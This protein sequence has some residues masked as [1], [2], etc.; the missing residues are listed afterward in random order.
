MNARRGTLWMLLAGLWAGT[1][2]PAWAVTLRWKPAPGATASYT[3]SLVSDTRSVGVGNRLTLSAARGRLEGTLTMVRPPKPDQ[4]ALDCRM[5]G[6]R[7]VV[8][9]QG[10][11]EP[12][13]VPTSVERVVMTPLGETVDWKLTRGD[14]A[15]LEPPMRLML[16]PGDLCVFEGY[17]AFPERDL[18]PGDTW[19]GYYDEKPSGPGE[20]PQRI[21]YQSTLMS[22]GHFRGRPCA[23]IA[24]TYQ[25]APV[26]KQAPQPASE[27][28]ATL[29]AGDV[30]WCFDV[31]RSMILYYT[32]TMSTTALLTAQEGNQ[33]FFASLNSQLRIVAHMTRYGGAP[34]AGPGSKSRRTN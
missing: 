1:S 24:T 5:T 21:S 32:E 13:R 3:L 33:P 30:F 11:P 18:K 12:R 16:E 27:P 28:P 22:L 29:M 34:L 26:P 15:E 19:S 23:R 31:E 2:L 20:E 7:L 8:W 6:G 17:G 9:L 14:L 10:A 4:V 25:V